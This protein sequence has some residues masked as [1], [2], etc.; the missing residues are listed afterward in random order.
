M[1]LRCA[2]NKILPPLSTYATSHSGSVK[3]PFTKI[4]CV[5]CF[6]ASPK[7]IGCIQDCN[8][9]GVCVAYRREFSLVTGIIAHLYN[10]LLHFATHYM[11]H[12]VFSSTSSPTAAS[13]DY[14]SSLLRVTLGLAVC[15]QSVR[16]PLETHYQ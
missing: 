16:K 8:A 3:Q 13:R 2:T 14:L 15:H 1:L 11:T 7:N 5:I 12:C 6:S 4:I 10:L 9:F